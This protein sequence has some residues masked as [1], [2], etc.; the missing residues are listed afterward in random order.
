M[1]LSNVERDWASFR[2][3]APPL[4]NIVKPRSFHTLHTKTPEPQADIMYPTVHFSR[5]NCCLRAVLTRDERNLPRRFACSVVPSYISVLCKCSCLWTSLIRC[6]PGSEPGASTCAV[7]PV[8]WATPSRVET[9]VKW[10]KLGCMVLAWILLDPCF[11]S[12]SAC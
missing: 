5:F 8:I 6:W 1:F 10:M 9:S 7:G 3:W 11:S 4:I 2:P 12:P